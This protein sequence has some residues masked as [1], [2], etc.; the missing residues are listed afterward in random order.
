MHSRRSVAQWKNPRGTDL[1]S[2]VQTKWYFKNS[3]YF[4]SLRNKQTKP[5]PNPKTTPQN[6]STWRYTGHKRE[7]NHNKVEAILPRFYWFVSISQFP[8]RISSFLLLLSRHPFELQWATWGS[9][10]EATEQFYLLLSQL[11]FLSQRTSEL[12]SSQQLTFTAARGKLGQLEKEKHQPT[13]LSKEEEEV[14]R[15]SQCQRGPCETPSVYGYI[16]NPNTGSFIQLGL[17]QQEPFNSW[18]M[19]LSL[20]GSLILAGIHN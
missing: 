11:N 9:L 16:C 2:F 13:S 10:T 3:F 5:L 8:F 17:R 15:Y 4:C 19:W 1:K 20:H 6:K 14:E 7:E 12:L 18:A